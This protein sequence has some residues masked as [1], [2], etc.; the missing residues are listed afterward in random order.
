MNKRVSDPMVSSRV[1]AAGVVDLNEIPGPPDTGLRVMIVDDNQDAAAMLAILAR[2]WG[3]DVIIAHSSAEAVRVAVDF[4]PRVV[5]LDLGLPDR[6]GYDLA[7]ML[8]A[9][10]RDHLMYFVAVTGW[11]QIADQI[12]SNAS[13]IT[14]H[15]IKPV[16]HDVLKEI[17][18]AYAITRDTADN[19]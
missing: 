6:H 5:L 1:R 16:N 13:G 15:L 8:R 4:R 19:R 14:H 10:F 12:R 18:A 2:R 17:L 3:H 11:N 7:D 9:Q